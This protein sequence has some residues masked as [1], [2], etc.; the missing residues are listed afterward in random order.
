MLLIVKL[1]NSIITPVL[2]GVWLTIKW[3]FGLLIIRLLWIH[4][5]LTFN[6]FLIPINIWIN[7]PYFI[8]ILWRWV[9][10]RIGYIKSIIFIITVSCLSLIIISRC[11]Y[12]LVLR[13]ILVILSLLKHVLFILFKLMYLFASN[14]INILL[15]FHFCFKHFIFYHLIF[16]LLWRPLSLISIFLPLLKLPLW[17]LLLPILLSVHNLMSELIFVSTLI[18]LYSVFI[19]IWFPLSI[20]IF[21]SCIRFV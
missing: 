19:F 7:K 21:M 10:F 16:I 8:V 6:R 20:S 14:L 9:S 3:L 5:R 4:I 15:F 13:W 2:I 12:S 11:P 1:L 18:I 17:S